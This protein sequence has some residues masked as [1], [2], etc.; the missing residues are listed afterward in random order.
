MYKAK[1]IVRLAQI[2][3]P[4]T[5]IFQRT[6]EEALKKRYVPIVEI[7]GNKEQWNGVGLSKSIEGTIQTAADMQ[8]EF[9][10]ALFTAYIMPT[11]ILNKDSMMGTAEQLPLIFVAIRNSFGNEW[12]YAET[13]G[14]WPTP[15]LETISGVMDTVLAKRQALCNPILEWHGKEAEAFIQNLESGMK[16]AFSLADQATSTLQ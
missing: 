11:A 3:F 14:Q 6:I 8:Q 7:E 1:T 4:P 5:R 9:P 15:I 2:E 12:F 16:R 13:R 10:D